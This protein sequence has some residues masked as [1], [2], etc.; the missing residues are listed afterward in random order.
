MTDPKIQKLYQQLVSGE[1]SGDLFRNETL[2]S[3]YDHNTSQVFGE[4]LEQYEAGIDF[5]LDLTTYKP[6][7]TVVDLGC[8][9]GISTLRLLVRNPARVIG[10]DF[11]EPMLRQ[12]REK[13]KGRDNVEFKVGSAEELSDVVNDVDK[14]VSVNVFQYISNP[15]DVLKGIYNALNPNSGY[16][17]NVRVKAPKEQSIYFQLFRAIEKAMSEELGKKM[18]L[19]ELKGLEPK[20]DRSDLEGLATRN[21]FAV[22]RYEEKP[23]VIEEKHLRA[24]HQL[25]LDG[26]RTGLAETLGEETAKRIIKRVQTELS[27]MYSASGFVAGTEAYICLRKKPSPK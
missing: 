10:L 12:A 26:M 17:F 24:I 14:V 6:T 8:G 2:A 18:E 20:Y 19:P 1:R 7:D 23:I 9:T 27:K 3:G 25:A 11:S 5:L 21:G 16:L 13:L 22:A 4:D 15:D